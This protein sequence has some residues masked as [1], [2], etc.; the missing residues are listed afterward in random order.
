MRFLTPDPSPASGRGGK[1]SRPLA[2]LYLMAAL[3]LS[4]LCSPLPLAAQS[5][6]PADPAWE[7]ERR[8]HELLLQAE[9][10]RGLRAKRRIDAKTH[11]EQELAKTVTE[12]FREEMPAATLQALEISLKSFGLI[13]ESFDLKAFLPELL[14]EQ[15]AGYYDPETQGLRLI[16]RNGIP[17]GLEED[18]GIEPQYLEEMVLVHELTHALQ[19]QHF[20]LATFTKSDP[21]SDEATA[22]QA[23][24]EGDATLTMMN[25]LLRVPIEELPGAEDLLAAAVEASEPWMARSSGKLL[26]EA[27]P[28][29]RETMMFSYLPGNF[30]CISVR[31]KGGQKLL[32]HAFR[33]D[34]PRSSEQILH[35]E[36]WHGRR[37][38]PIRVEWPDLASALP[39]FAKVAEGEM[40]EI[41][42]RILLR[43]SL[44]DEERAATAAAGWGGDRFAV[45]Q[46]GDGKEGHRLLAWI[47]EWDSTD[48]AAEFA[49]AAQELG[50]GW[51][52]ERPAAQRVIVLR[53]LPGDMAPQQAG[54]LREQLAAAR[55]QRPAGQSIDL[56]SLGIRDEDRASADPEKLQRLLQNPE[57]RKRFGE[58]TGVAGLGEEQEGTIDPEGLSYTSPRFTLRL[59]DAA[60]A[61]GWKLE[62]PPASG[63]VVMARAADSTAWVGFGLQKTAPAAESSLQTMFPLFEAG[64]SSSIPEYKSL[65]GHVVETASGQ[66]YDHQFEG[67]DEHRLHGLLRLQQRGGTLVFAAAIARLE[68]WEASEPVLRS[69]LD[70]LALAPEAQAG[71]EAPEPSSPAPPGD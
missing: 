31:Q 62:V 50:P 7:E 46:K 42:V 20:G 37:D 66:A 59:P 45:Y 32:D 34:P 51:R 21:L 63:I 28:Y 19:D 27:P 8:L 33:S 15:I 24:V 9:T 56:A 44:K 68:N 69:V 35:P 47:T 38:D 22:R 18:I 71:K 14:T 48:D 3:A 29:I 30:F 65:G 43:E 64:F 10:W 16:R 41:A 26:A 13:P 5:A 49:S 70:A 55:S 60:A 61:A 12:S 67:G 25:A 57:I 6:P 4:L 23:L 2:P 40:G 54:R 53:G 36:K 11:A 58:I 17:G 1:S 39:G 52:I